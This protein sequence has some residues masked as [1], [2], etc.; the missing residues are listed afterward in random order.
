MS[1]PFPAGRK[2]RS[3]DPPISTRVAGRFAGP[4]VKLA[5]GIRLRC[6]FL[7]CGGSSYR[8]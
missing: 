8:F 5:A 2:A 7:A 3:R 6:G 4:P 1:M